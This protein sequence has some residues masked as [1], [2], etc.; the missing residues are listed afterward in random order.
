MASLRS[1]QDPE[2]LKQGMSEQAMRETGSGTSMLRTVV[3]VISAC[4]I[5]GIMQGIHDNYG[6]MM[7]SL[8]P[9]TG[10]SYQEISFIIGVGAVLY[11]LVQPC[12]G[13]LALRKSNSFV[14]LIGIAMILTGLIAT[15]MCRQFPTMLL[16]FGI[17]LPSGTGALSFGIVMSA[18]T[19]MIGEKKAAAVSG[20]VQASAG[21]GDALMSPALQFLISWHGIAFSMGS[22]AMLMAATLPVIFWIGAKG[23]EMPA[24]ERESASAEKERLSDII[25]DA[26]RNRTYRLIFIGFSTCGFN[27]SIIES[28]L[29]SQFVSW[30]ISQNAA[31]M[32]MMIYGIMTMLGA[33][34]TGF[35]CMRFPMKNVLGTVYGLRVLISLS[36]L[37]IPGSLPLALIATG[38]LG[39][40][41]DSTVPPTTGLITREFGARKMAVYYGIALVGHQVGAFLSSSFGGICAE[42]FGTYAPLWAANAVLC[43]IAASASYA[44]RR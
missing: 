13:I 35:L 5:Y 26:F 19:P 33:M 24:Q 7:K 39:A 8:V 32:V 12:F 18:I 20:I 36:M 22:F 16:F 2:D 42:Q 30:G 10:V 3:L 31:S 37:L 14:M 23:R 17:I 38:C 41:G 29:F 4:L 28:H 27:M 40:T 9:H 11:G 25:R 6:I 34:A 1:S 21:V 43:A 44:I 15:P